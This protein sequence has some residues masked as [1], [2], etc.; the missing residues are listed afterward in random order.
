MTIDGSL[1]GFKYTTEDTAELITCC[2]SD[3]ASLMYTSHYSQGR[4]FLK[5]SYARLGL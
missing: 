5:I 2:V 4:E 1:A 3:C